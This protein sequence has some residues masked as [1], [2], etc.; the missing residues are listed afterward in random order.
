MNVES[1]SEGYPLGLTDTKTDTG[2]YFN[3]NN[4]VVKPLMHLHFS[5]PQCLRHN[6]KAKSTFWLQN[7]NEI[8]C[9]LPSNFPQST[10]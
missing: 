9:M 5:W 7:E 6:N 4:E 1:E 10:K 8:V 2:I 3:T